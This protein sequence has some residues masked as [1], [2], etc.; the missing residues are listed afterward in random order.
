ME[1]SDEVIPA[2]LVC[3][4]CGSEFKTY[5]LLYR[6]KVVQCNVCGYEFVYW[7]SIIILDNFLEKKGGMK[8][9]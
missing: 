9:G 7:G 2:T 4:K 1:M 3:P 6:G 8:G 5:E